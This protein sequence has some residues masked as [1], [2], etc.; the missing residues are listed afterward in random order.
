M[1]FTSDGQSWGFLFPLCKIAAKGNGDRRTSLACSFG[2]SLGDP[3]KCSNALAG[4]KEEVFR[5]FGV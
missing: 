1:D 5:R 2:K 4:P 3:M